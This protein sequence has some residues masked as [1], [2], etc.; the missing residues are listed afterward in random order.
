[1][2]YEEFYINYVSIYQDYIHYFYLPN[3]GFIVWRMGTGENV[4]LLH[5]QTFEKGK[6]HGRKLFYSMLEDMVDSRPYYSVFGFTRISNEEAQAFYGALGFDLQEVRGVY[7]D[8]GAILFSQNYEILVEK[9]NEYAD[10][11]QE[12]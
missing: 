8:G 9:M 12:Q 4:E 2:D 5:I 10:Y 1:M 7:K 6:G 3:Q 11:S